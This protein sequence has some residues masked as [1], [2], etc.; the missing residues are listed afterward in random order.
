MC[1]CEREKV[2]ESEI[3]RVR[4]RESEIFTERGRE[5]GRDSTLIP[6][7]D[8]ERLDTDARC[9]HVHIYAPDWGGERGRKIDRERCKYTNTERI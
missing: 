3:E 8:R 5:I 6:E 7:R 4:V 9:F 2:S 1:V